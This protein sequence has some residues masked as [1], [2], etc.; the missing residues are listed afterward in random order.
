MQAQHRVSPPPS[1]VG[2]LFTVLSYNIENAFD[3]RHDE[4]KD[5]LEFCEG[6]ER[7]WSHTRLMNKLKGV[8]KVIAAADEKRPVDLIGLCEVEN[9]TVM[10]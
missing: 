2:G 6:G 5:D 7:K 4:G 1:G 9:D 10:Q 3:T 8:S